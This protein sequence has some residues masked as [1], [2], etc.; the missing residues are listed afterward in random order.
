MEI[1]TENNNQSRW[2]VVEPSPSRYIYNTATCKT[3]GSL[4]R[5]GLEGESEGQGVGREAVSPRNV[6]IYTCKISPT[7]LPEHESKKDNSNGHAN[8]SE[9]TFMGTQSYKEN[10]RQPRNA[11]SRRNSFPT[12]WLYNNK[13]LALKTHI[14]ITLYRPSGLNLCVC[15]CVCTCARVH[16]CISQ[17]LMKKEPMCLKEAK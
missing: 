10:Y 7:W 17:Q 6:R 3:Q 13:L 8:I 2:R 15:V 4:P 9:E 1:I 14:Q 11:E 12:N 5:R 16:A